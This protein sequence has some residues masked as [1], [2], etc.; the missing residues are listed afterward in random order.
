MVLDIHFIWVDHMD[1]SKPKK[2][3]FLKL[4]K[5]FNPLKNVNLQ[6]MS[7]FKKKEKIK[8]TP[9]YGFGYL[10]DIGHSKCPT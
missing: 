3:F 4:E 9:K 5:M 2:F 8:F 1:H 7:N 10:F 6:K